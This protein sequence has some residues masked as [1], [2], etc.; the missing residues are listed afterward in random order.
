MNLKKYMN[1]RIVL[2]IMCATLALCLCGSVY[3]QWEEPVVT[4]DNY[5]RYEYR[6]QEGTP[7][8][9]GK[10]PSGVGSVLFETNPTGAKVFID[11]IFQGETPLLINNVTDGTYNAR[12]E[13]DGYLNY[14]T[15]F[16]VAATLQSHVTAGLQPRLHYFFDHRELYTTLIYENSRM[17]AEGWGVGNSWGVYFRNINLEQTTVVHIGISNTVSFEGSVGYGFIMGHL[18]RFRLTPQ[19]GYSGVWYDHVDT[20]VSGWSGY[21]R[22][23]LNFKC[24]FTEQYAFS[25]TLLYDK[26]GFG[27]R[28]G[29]LFYVN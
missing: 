25:A 22:G 14:Y 20:A 5:Q 6:V 26:T 7:L 18:N 11:D 21:L 8:E 4:D 23:A 19:I 2:R 12:F 10:R 17:N 3:A 1:L 28:A 29:V 16:D 24:A 9:F 13:K 15:V 27:F